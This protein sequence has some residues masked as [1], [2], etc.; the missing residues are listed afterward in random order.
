MHELQYIRQQ[1]LEEPT[2]EP[3]GKM[4]Q[5]EDG[6]DL[7]PTRRGTATADD[8]LRAALDNILDGFALYG[9]DGR[10]EMCNNAFRSMHGYT[11]TDAAPGVTTYD[12]LGQVDF[13]NSDI[14]RLPLSFDERRERLR[15]TGPTVVLQYLGDRVLERRQ[16]TTPD[17]GIVSIV[18]D[19]TDRTRLE[20]ALQQANETLRQHSEAK[21]A[22][23][24]NMAHEIRTPM[25]AILGFAELMVKR[26]YGD[27]GDT[28]YGDYAKI[29]MESGDHLLSLLNDVLDVSKIEAGT[30]ELNET[31]LDLP[32]MLTSVAT[33]LQGQAK[34]SGV[35]IL[36]ACDAGPAGIY[37][38]ERA[39]RQILINL[40]SNGIKFTPNGGSVTMSTAVDDAG[41]PLLRV[42]DTG[43]GIHQNE[44]NKVF[45][46]F[47]QVQS[48]QTHGGPGTGL[49]LTVTKSLVASH[50]GTISIDSTPGAG[51]TVTV[52]LPSRRLQSVPRHQG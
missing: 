43:I 13:E 38:D 16:S 41:R 3:S 23:L 45:E 24:S 36:L 29:I 27:L 28:R 33:M 50:G 1:R 34:E 11:E 20:E 12:R 40:V 51:T 30:L 35:Q 31:V 46:P 39:I 22:F 37:G 14:K 42:T 4:Q 18:R 8:R 5:R 49:G 26:V 19:I 21:T 52:R 15:E 2:T 9:P 47:H 6:L 17:G 32:K 25:N 10:L 44:L 48:A 7:E